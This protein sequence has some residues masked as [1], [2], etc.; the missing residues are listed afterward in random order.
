MQIAFPTMTGVLHAAD[1][2]EG[3][4]YPERQLTIGGSEA[5]ARIGKSG[6]AIAITEE[7]VRYSQF[8]V[9]GMHLRA[10]GAALA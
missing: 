6:V 3:M 9:I 1:V 5:Q 8:D 2:M 7:M 4:A 10:A